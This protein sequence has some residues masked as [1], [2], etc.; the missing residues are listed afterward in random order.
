MLKML[1]EMKERAK[2]RVGVYGTGWDPESVMGLLL[3]FII[4]GILAF[5][6][7]LFVTTLNS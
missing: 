3:P 2:A 5:M 6:G 7:W 4:V 1:L